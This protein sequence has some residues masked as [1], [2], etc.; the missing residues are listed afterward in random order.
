[1][2]TRALRHLIESLTEVRYHHLKAALL[3]ADPDRR[4]RNR[5][6]AFRVEPLLEAVQRELAI[7]ETHAVRVPDDIER[8]DGDLKSLLAAY[9]GF[10]GADGAVDHTGAIGTVRRRERD[11]RY[12][13]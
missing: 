8:A 4:E 3:E 1:M 11:R 13:S 10:G 7:R 2:K 6:E 12:A 9:L 5:D